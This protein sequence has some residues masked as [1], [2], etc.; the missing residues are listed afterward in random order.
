MKFRFL[1]ILFIINCSPRGLGV[2]HA[3]VSQE[4]VARYSSSSDDNASDIAVD[5]AGNVYV[6]GN[7][8]GS[9]GY[10]DYATVKY[11]SAGLELWSE[12]YNGPGNNIDRA[13]SV[14]VDN[15]GNI[16]VTGFSRSGP[17]AAYNDFATIKY[18]PSGVERWVRRYNGGGSDIA[19]K[20]SID[21]NGGILVGGWST[22][23][24]TGPDFTVV[25][26]D[27]NGNILWVRTYDS[28]GNDNQYD[29][30]VA[31]AVD[32][33]GNVYLTGSVGGNNFPA[34]DWATVKWNSQGDF[35]WVQRFN[36]PGSGSDYSQ[37]IAT[38]D[39]GNVYV[40]G[41]VWGNNNTDFATI[42]YNSTGV[43]Q[44]V[45]YYNGGS[46]YTAHDGGFSI[47]VDLSGNVYVTG[48]SKNPNS[49][50]FDY[51]TIKYFASGIQQWVTRF[52]GLFN[53]DDFPCR[54]EER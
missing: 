32:L 46:I 37:A 22:R 38:S 29:Y 4:W 26:Y 53:S 31:M 23:S 16:Y 39:S 28:G 36:G 13:V 47:A 43:Q 49:N 25:K 17:S 42:K 44:W 3:Q 30:A 10:E 34:P 45:K 51:V 40:T 33:S 12:R 8:D 2:V 21:F 11:N 24:V 19:C 5:N 48:D 7:S 15:S 35:Q 6:T 52:N 41:I 54:S 1:V 20:V 27:S 9:N 18:S 50:N 14:A